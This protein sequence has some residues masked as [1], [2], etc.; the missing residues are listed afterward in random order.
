MNVD[1]EN[2]MKAKGVGITELAKRMGV[3][4]QTIYYYIKQGNN[5]P[6]SQLQKIAGAIGVPVTDL[7]EK[8]EPEPEQENVI[9][10]PACGAKLKVIKDNQQ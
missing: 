7:F 8:P 5:N 4:R 3:N 9:T 2:T 10:C 1:I 6:L